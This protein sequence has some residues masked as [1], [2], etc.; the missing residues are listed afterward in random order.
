MTA[1]KPEKKSWRGQERRE[2]GRKMAPQ[3]L[4]GLGYEV[5]KEP[6]SFSFIP[7][8]KEQW[9]GQV[10]PAVASLKESRN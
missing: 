10:S 9:K 8:E 4:P 7:W 5:F 3:R 2:Q 1:K 6:L